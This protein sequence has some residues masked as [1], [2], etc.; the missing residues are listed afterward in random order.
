MLTGGRNYLLASRRKIITALVKKKYGPETVPV[1]ASMILQGNM[2]VNSS[3]AAA[4]PTQTT[5]S[6]TGQPSP[7]VSQT[8]SATDS[9]AIDP[10]PHGAQYIPNEGEVLS[11]DV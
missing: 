4:M 11:H 8:L 9:G 5:L 7:Q 2:P 1:S 10:R 6:G 3:V